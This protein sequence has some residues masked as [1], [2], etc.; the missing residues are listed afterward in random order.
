MNLNITCGTLNGE[1][2]DIINKSITI[3]SLILLFI[4][5][6]LIYLFTGLI[7][8]QKSK[9]KYMQIWII[10]TIFSIAV[11]I[12]ISL[13]PNLVQNIISFFT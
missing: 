7:V 11:L 10:A 12:A 5:M 6:I 8:L 4:S 9:G 3:P 2:T 1:L 13:M